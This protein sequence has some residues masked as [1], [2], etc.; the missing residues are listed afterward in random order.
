MVD[1]R[2]LEENKSKMLENIKARNM[3]SNLDEVLSLQNKRR[4]LLQDL[5]NKRQRRNEVATSMK[6]KM[7]KDA[8]DKLIDEGK[9][10]KSEIAN[11]EDELKKVEE[12]Y[13]ILASTLP[14]YLDE[15]APIGIEGEGKILKRVGKIKKRNFELKDH[16]DIATNL[17]I[18]D[19]E[20]GAKVSGSKFYFLK[21]EAVLLEL[22]LTQF[23]MTILLK[24][25]FTPFITPD[26]ARENILK[27]IGFNPRGEESNIYTIE[28]TDTAL[29]ATSEITL[30]GYYADTIFNKDEL[31]KLMC[32]VSHCFRKE[33]GASGQYS[34]GLYRVHQFSKVEMFIVCLPED[35]KKLHE[36]LLSIE[37][38]I[39]SA[40]EIPYQV[41][42]IP[43][44]DLGAPAARKFD[45][46]AWM[47]A[48][49]SG[50]YGEVTSTSN[51]TDYQARSL[52]IRYKED[53]GG[54][55]F[56]HTLNGTAVAISR[57]LVAIF[58]NYQNE[59][60]SIDIPKVLLPYM[61]GKTKIQR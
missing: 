32:G 23:A 21:N 9:N 16:L 28:D 56:T 55:V 31:P 11:I 47:P 14:N 44:G 6:N 52:N 18:L 46:E 37:E 43:S 53:D 25:G 51:C 29:I 7:E 27:G 26:L 22:A 30:G 17:D 40:L 5:D 15:D 35:S 3:S 4:I 48:R 39:Y 36:K 20:K 42:D 34:K 50:S 19:F 49:M 10:L 2:F 59:D 61:V 24:H 45:I 54:N 60:G 33:S 1:L 12:E 58:E 8:R 38:E 57:A 41:V 13:F